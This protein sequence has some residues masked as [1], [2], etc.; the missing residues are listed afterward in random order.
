[1]FVNKLYRD[2]ARDLSCYL[3]CMLNG[4]SHNRDDKPSGIQVSAC[5]LK[6]LL[7]KKKKKAPENKKKN[8][9]IPNGSNNF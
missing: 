8:V 4:T 6:T 5:L 7:K 2:A 1:M 3:W 9:S